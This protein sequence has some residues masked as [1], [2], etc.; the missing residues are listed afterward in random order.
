MLY[1]YRMA[2]VA[3]SGVDACTYMYIQFVSMISE[4]VRQQTA[5]TW[6]VHVYVYILL[7]IGRD[8]GRSDHT[9]AHSCLCPGQSK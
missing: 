1:V 3:A 7:Y 4:I 6:Y 5:K 2:K 9:E 8:T